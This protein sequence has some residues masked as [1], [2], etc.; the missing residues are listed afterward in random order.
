MW[1]PSDG[2]ELCVYRLVRTSHLTFL[3]LATGEQLSA[4]LA[5]EQRLL[6]QAHAGAAL[7]A[8]RAS[9]QVNT[10]FLSFFLFFYL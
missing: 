10:G 5:E 7:Q 2:S 6:Q 4:S 9:E 8:K 1:I 3:F